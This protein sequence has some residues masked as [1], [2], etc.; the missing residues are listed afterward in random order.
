MLC[1]ISYTYYFKTA[2]IRVKN[3]AAFKVLKIS[4]R[5][6]ATK[7]FFTFSAL[8]IMR[9]KKIGKQSCRRLGI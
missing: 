9:N 5:V 6:S 1:K 7:G 4:F 8:Q 2:G 3:V